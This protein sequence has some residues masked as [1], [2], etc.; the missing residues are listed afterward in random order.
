MEMIYLLEV[1]HGNGEMTRRAFA[2]E[3]K[4]KRTLDNEEL[5]YLRECKVNNNAPT[6]VFK[7][8]EIKVIV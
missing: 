7:L 5:E 1:L 6:T 4:A 2:T 8:T 3:E